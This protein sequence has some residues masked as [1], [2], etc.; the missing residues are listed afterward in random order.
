MENVAGD[1]AIQALTEPRDVHRGRRAWRRFR[2]PLVTVVGLSLIVGVN[3]W[4]H[5][6]RGVERDAQAARDAMAAGRPDEARDPVRR[7]LRARPT[8]AEA[9]AVAAEVAFAE[10]NFTGVKSEYDTARA[11]GY[12]ETKLERA[13]ALW[14]VRF[15]RYA[16]AEPTLARAWSE[17]PRSDPAVNEAL[18]RIYLKTF[19]LES[20]RAVI[21]RWIKDAPADGRPFLWLTE[22]DRRIEVDAPE[23]WER[24]YREALL[25]DPGLDPARHGLAESLRRM[26]RNDEAAREYTQYLTRHPADPVALTGA[27][28]NALEMGDLNEASRHLDRALELAPTHPAA[29]K[30]R[31][32]VALSTGDVPSARRWLD[33]AVRADPFDSE[34]FQV[35]SRVQTML[36]DPAGAK[37]D[38]AIADRLKLDQK[39]LVELRESLLKQPGRDETKTKV[40]A[41]MLAH[42]REQDGLDWAMAIL[43]SQ[44]DHA[45]TCLMLADYYSKRPDGTGLANFYRLKAGAKPSTAQ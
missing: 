30:G 22:I 13:R 3:V 28:L 34:A 39:K 5:E 26:H 10:G 18:V 2:W 35:R 6:R 41:W 20:A 44:P 17:E 32:D 15:G 14:L 8:S 31:A 19:R 9:H 38:R 21:A 40:A 16:E 43:A 45:P 4:I 29:L 42:G 33:Q 1:K 11:L 37:A 25:R 36:G 12:P 23:S 24:R 7:W 27:G